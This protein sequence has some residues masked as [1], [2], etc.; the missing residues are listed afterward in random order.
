MGLR[1][2][3]GVPIRVGG[4]TA[5]PE[6]TFIIPTRYR[7][8]VPK[9]A[10]YACGAQMISNALR[11]VPQF[12]QLSVAFGEHFPA[13]KL[14]EPDP[15]QFMEF[16]Y[17]KMAPNICSTVE[18]Q[19]GWLKIK[20]EIRLTPILRTQRR[21][22]KDYMQET[23]FSEA[24]AWLVRT[25]EFHGREGTASLGFFLDQATCDVTMRSERNIQ[26]GR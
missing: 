13:N 9:D 1:K 2:G 19:W 14:R 11:S 26:P 21:F 10:S 18:D 17:R 25:W 20:W 3:S 23:G 15:L 8:K 16:S 24:A 4:R 7:S 6:D 5:M 22:A 12:E